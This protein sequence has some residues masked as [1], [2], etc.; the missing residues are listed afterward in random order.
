[1]EVDAVNIYDR[2]LKTRSFAVDQEITTLI[3][4]TVNRGMLLIHCGGTA[5]L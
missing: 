3:E 1:M 2:P 5:V 4:D